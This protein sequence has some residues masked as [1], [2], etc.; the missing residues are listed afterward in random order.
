MSIFD[1]TRAKRKTKSTRRLMGAKTFTQYGIE[2]Y[3]KNELVVFCIQPA[4]L[5]VLSPTNIDSK[6]RYMTMVLSTIPDIEFC[7]LDSSEQF[8]NNKVYIKS[9]LESER[10]PKVRK[11][12]QA[13]H[14]FLDEIQVETSTAREFLILARFRNAT[15]QQVFNGINRIEKTIRDQNFDVRLADKEDLKR[16]LAIYF[17]GNVT[18]NRMPDVDGE[19]SLIL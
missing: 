6:I 10:D 4:N 8:S 15:Q 12:L 14:D 5:S 1:K 3:D 16:I 17:E 13:D 19:D 11:L 9:R 2:T 18:S 7:C